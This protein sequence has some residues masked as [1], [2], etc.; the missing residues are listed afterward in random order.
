MSL[1]MIFSLCTFSRTIIVGFSIGPVTFVVSGSFT[2]LTS[3]LPGIG[4]WS[5]LKSN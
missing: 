2:S 3:N 4:S 1:E 5:E